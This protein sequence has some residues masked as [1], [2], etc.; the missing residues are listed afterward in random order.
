[1][2]FVF[3]V[4][5]GSAAHPLFGGAQVR[6][7]A[8]GT[9]L[10]NAVV[11]RQGDREIHR[12]SMPQPPQKLALDARF[13]PTLKGI[14]HMVLQANQSWSIF[15]GG[16]GVGVDI[17]PGFRGAHPLV[18][19]KATQM[20]PNLVITAQIRTDF[21]DVTNLWMDLA[22]QSWVQDYVDEHHPDVQLV[23]LGATRSTPP[24]WFAL[25][26]KQCRAPASPSIGALVFYR[27]ASYV[28]TSLVD[29]QAPGGVHSMQ[30]MNRYFLAPVPGTAAFYKKDTMEPDGQGGDYLYVRVGFEDAL[31]KS[32]KNVVLFHPL[33]SGNSFGDSRGVRLPTLLSQAMALLWSNQAVGVDTG[34]VQVGRLGVAGYSAGGQGLWDAFRN[35]KALVKE[36]YAFDPIGTVAHGDQAIQWACTTA[37]ARLRMVG[38]AQQN[39]V[40]GIA[41]GIEKRKARLPSVGPAGVTVSPTKAGPSFWDPSPVG[42]AWWNHAIQ[43]FTHRRRDLNLSHQFAVFGGS[44]AK[45]VSYLEEF[46]KGSGY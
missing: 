10:T 11:G 20:P 2:T 26:P 38:A 27:P 30:A 21:V 23:V 24:L 18:D 15:D 8:D 7:T 1:M 45:G 13:V 6:V 22:D 32:G 31:V 29:A 43:K 44:G 9:L 25:V 42:S 17:V 40:L 36:I 33:P 12:F 39:A 37:D 46:L 19:T 41:A 5:W 3:E 4:S 28:Y 34:N 14:P 16:F 35:N